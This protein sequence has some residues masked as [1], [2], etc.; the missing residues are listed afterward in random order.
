MMK[1]RTYENFI[2]VDGQPL[3][4][5]IN[6]RMVPNKPDLFLSVVFAL[7]GVLWQ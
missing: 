3:R 2:Y 4:A 6:D 7:E 1:M 5:R